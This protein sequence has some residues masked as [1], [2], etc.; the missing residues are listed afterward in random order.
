VGRCGLTIGQS[1]DIER[2]PSDGGGFGKNPLNRSEK[3]KK[4]IPNAFSAIVSCQDPDPA[5][6]AG[7]AVARYAKLT[8]TLE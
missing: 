5:G 1:H 8:D 3:P 6:D 7:Y 2:H 4:S